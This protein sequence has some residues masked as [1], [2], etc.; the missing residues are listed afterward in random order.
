MSKAK[1]SGN[2]ARRAAAAAEA[3]AASVGEAASP[4]P[5]TVEALDVVARL[6][7]KERRAKR[8]LMTAVGDARSQG[9]SWRAIGA[10]LG[11]TGEAIRR[12]W[13]RD[14]DHGFS[15]AAEF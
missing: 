9:Y 8:A 12:R 4:P 2:P 5:R 3:A 11:V 13:Q 10:R 6:G 15:A 7:A 14:Q 1:R